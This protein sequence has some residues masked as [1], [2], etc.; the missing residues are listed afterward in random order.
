MSLELSTGWHASLRSYHEITVPSNNLAPA[1]RVL[2]DL[3][4]HS[5]QWA[6]AAA[7]MEAVR[8]ACAPVLGFDPDVRLAPVAEMSA[9]IGGENLVIPAALDFS[10]W[11]RDL[12][13]QRIAEERR[14][15]PDTI[16][17]HDDVDPGHPLVVDALAFQAAHALGEIPP[18][19]C[20]LILAASGHGDPG[21]R[22]QSYRL[23]RLLW[24]QMGFAR[25]EVGFLRHVQPFLG[26]VLE[27]CAGE[28]MPWVVIFQGQW[29]TEHVEYTRV[30]VENTRRSHA[31]PV[32]FH[33]AQPPGAHALLTA[34]YAQRIT[35]LWQEKRVRS[36]ARAPSVR[37]TPPET[38]CIRT[39]GGGLIAGATNQK[40]LAEAV[41]RI[42][43]QAKFERV[44]VKVTWHGY[45]TGAY[46]DPA[47]LDLLLGALPA[48]AIVLEGHT[49]SRNLGGAEF[50][51]EA[52]AKENRAWIRQQEAEFLR[53][54]G[55]HDVLV[56]H[57]A[58]YVNVT[59]AFW[60]EDAGDG[61]PTSFVPQ[62]LL[63]FRGCPMLSFAK[64]KGPTRLGISNLFGLI[65]L[66]LR[67]AWHG[68]NITWFA[69][70]CC[71]VAKTYGSLFDLSGVVEALYSAVRWNR[72]GLYRSRWG[73]YDLI[74]DAGYI[75]ASRGLVAADI[76]A[77]RLQGQDVQN[78][79][80]FDV[81]RQQL[82]WDEEAA[83]AAL[84][85][86]ARQRFA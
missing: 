84:P 19:K 7:Q 57:R 55:L 3:G 22:A 27:R 77:S 13:G 41:G 33:F 62:C 52:E 10:L 42:L 74:R 26:H 32:G 72:Q 48:P 11:E 15:H 70:A 54:T 66:P 53:R 34:W 12:L 64:F 23:M 39:F 36:A 86:E 24:E 2:S 61:D 37:Q 76:L 1:F 47:A 45:A 79:A 9:Q 78:S 18:Q 5:P 75:T 82:G 85:E 71:E 63:D 73:N 30:I 17:Y 28:A 56:R 83:N 20:G 46:T 67:S 21:S 16:I 25:A 69:R 40:H 65:P 68:P 60:D 81:V 80:F 43:P 31:E 58:E 35:R 14:S 29:E 8:S 50:D 59:E 44:L 4:P 51:W 49:S 38:A 6:V